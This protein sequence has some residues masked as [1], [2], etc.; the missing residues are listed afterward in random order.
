VPAPGVVL[1]FAEG[2]RPS[3]RAIER[4]LAGV[5]SGAGSTRAR[6]SHLPEGDAGW[7]ELLSSGLT[8]DLSGLAPGPGAD[9]PERR[10]VLG[11]SPDT[12]AAKLEAVAL[13]PGPHVSAGAAL[14][15]VLRVLCGLAAA[16]AQALPVEV[17]GWRTA[18]TWMAPAYFT[19][20]ID[21]WLAGGAFPSLGLTALELTEGGAV[22]SNGLAFFTGQE[23]RVEPVEGATPAETVKLA[24]RIVDLLVGQGAVLTDEELAGPD[25]SVI[26]ARPDRG[27]G[28]V[29]VRRSA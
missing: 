10:Q 20:I 19:R 9:L 7:L 15:P 22:V 17:V 29:T 16:L 6:I 18:G 1:F 24:V 4:A 27:G 8:F 26:S 12:L 21:A 2:K 14:L 11:L 13:V 5:A 3:A 25:G 23:V 28:L